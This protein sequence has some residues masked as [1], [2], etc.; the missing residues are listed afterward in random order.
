MPIK[1]YL[2]VGVELLKLLGMIG[3]M[4]YVARDV[5]TVYISC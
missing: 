4:K 5:C 1:R 2:V 3:R